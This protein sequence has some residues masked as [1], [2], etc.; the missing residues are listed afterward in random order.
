MQFMK[1]FYSG[2]RTFTF[3]FPLSLVL[4]IQTSA[5]LQEP[6]VVQIRYYQT[7][8]SR[9]ENKLSKKS[10]LRSITPSDQGL[11]WQLQKGRMSLASSWKD[12]RDILNMHS[13]LTDWE[14]AAISTFPRAAELY[15]LWWP[16]CTS[17]SVVIV[18]VSWRFQ[19]TRNLHTG[20]TWSQ[21][22][23]RWTFH[24]HM[25]KGL[26]HS[27]PAHLIITFWKIYELTLSNIIFVLK[28][29]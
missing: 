10:Q 21:K 7:H 11:C 9:Y 4:N 25:C 15:H 23:F 2:A 5:H 8:N 26:L 28:L 29:K 22:S 13:F 6:R 1:H 18:P 24:Q 20:C 3:G 16:R 14:L 17:Q 19:R 12:Q 27:N